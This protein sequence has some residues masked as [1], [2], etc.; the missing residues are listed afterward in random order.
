MVTGKEK[1]VDAQLVADIT[2]RACTTQLENRT[3]IVIIFGDAD[4]MPA[5]RVVLRYPGWQVEVCMW[6]NDLQLSSDL[7]RLPQKEHNVKVHYFD[8]FLEH[9]YYVYQHEIQCQRPLFIFLQRRPLQL[10]CV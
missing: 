6:Q 4:V 5:I 1:G 9:N 8:K 3:T 10:F 7:K 2:D